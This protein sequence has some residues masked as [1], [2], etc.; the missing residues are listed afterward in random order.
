MNR[1]NGT[2][3]EESVIFTIFGAGA[4]GSLVGGVLAT[5]HPVILV[6]REDHLGAI[7]EQGLRISG[8][9]RHRVHPKFLVP[10]SRGVDDF[11][12]AWGALTGELDLS[13]FKKHFVIICVKSY[14]TKS[15]LKNI[16]FI[17]ESDMF[18]DDLKKRTFFVSLQNGIEN[19]KL[20]AGA[21]GASQV[22]GGITTEG[23]TFAGPGHII[24][25]GKGQTTLGPMD[26]GFSNTVK[27]SRE[28]VKLFNS[29]GLKA[30]FCDNIYSKIWTKAIINS[31]INPITAITGLEN[32]YILKRREL[33]V[34]AK[35]ACMEAAAVAEANLLSLACDN[36]WK[37]VKKV[38]KDTAGNRSSMLQD[39]QSGKR[40]EINCICGVIIKY[41]RR[42]DLNVPTQCMLH[43]LVRNIE[44][45]NEL[46]TGD[47]SEIERRLSRKRG[48]SQEAE[49]GESCLS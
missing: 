20:I 41:G 5:H 10:V 9:S 25:A 49:E 43:A 48:R 14:Q 4:M 2:Q 15:I 39:I 21:V 26:I 33:E 24:H 45:S 7:R 30:Y 19:E 44:L 34:L 46:K 29:A 35:R 47:R 22:I 36:P 42:E 11:T 27:A 32:G 3:M 12:S 37:E 31:S 23:I 13:S 17:Y 38:I 1:E 18:P 28:L 6:G 16:Q 8:K 40:T